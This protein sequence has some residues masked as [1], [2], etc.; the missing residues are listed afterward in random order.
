MSAPSATRPVVMPLPDPKYLRPAIHPRTAELHR[1]F[2]QVCAS[3]DLEKVIGLVKAEIRD[4]EYLTEG[5]LAAVF[6]KHFR[7]V[8]YL[9][10]QG[11]VIDRAVANAAASVR[12]LAI[13]RLL[14][15]RGWDINAPVMGNNTALLY[16]IYTNL[17]FCRF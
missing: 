15:E 8:E 6:Q 16:V 12:S 13:F 5:L 17:V 2:Q 10:D 9:L 11:A 3:G 1:V 4:V 14:L 7:I